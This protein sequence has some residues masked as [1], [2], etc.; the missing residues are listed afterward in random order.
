MSEPYL[1][2]HRPELISL[3]ERL[4]AKTTIQDDDCWICLA[5]GIESRY[6]TIWY[7]GESVSCHVAS[8][9]VHK[10]PIPNGIWVL[11]TCDVKRCINPEHLF[12]GTAFDNMQ[13]MHAKGRNDPRHGW[14]NHSAV[15]DDDKVHEIRA[16]LQSD[17]TQ[18]QIAN[19][20][21]VSQSVIS[22]IKF[23]KTWSHIP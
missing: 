15:L 2:L 10:G 17:M 11:H 9:M 18:Q 16:L 7:K 4:L 8:W 13:D 14:L 5:G 20:F 21:N 12:L 3:K 19:R 22:N 6:G 23:R 1:V